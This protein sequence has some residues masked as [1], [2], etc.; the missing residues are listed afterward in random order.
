MKKLLNVDSITP[1]D[2]TKRV[3][4]AQTPASIDLISYEM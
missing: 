3:P 4:E 2:Y 1:H